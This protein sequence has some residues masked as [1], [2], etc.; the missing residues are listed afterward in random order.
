MSQVITKEIRDGAGME[1]GSAPD[2]MPA[3]RLR[4]NPTVPQTEANISMLQAAEGGEAEASE[5]INLSLR[6]HQAGAKEWEHQQQAA[7]LHQWAERMVLEFKLQIPVPCLMIEG[8]RGRYGHFRCGRNG[9]GLV[10][11]IALDE[12]HL[13]SDPYAETLDTLLHEL[14][15]SWQK[16]HGRPGRRN[17]H[18][19]QFRQKAL[20]LGL[21]IDEQGCGG[22]IPGDTPFTNL[23]RR[24]GV[25]VPERPLAP[26]RAPARVG[27][28]LKLYICS[29]GVRVRVGRSSFNARCLD[30]GGRFEL[31]SSGGGQ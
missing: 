29:C 18:N 22:Y 14:L 26:Q 12:S 27:S 16:R 21:S 25:E 20:S 8:L 13:A 17:Y 11:E 4:L 30:C 19:Q 1:A 15:H 24:F 5:P 2:V 28:K 3:T 7:A 23:L 31:V 6:E 9:F 10:D